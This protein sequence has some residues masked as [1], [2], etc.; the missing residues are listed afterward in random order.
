MGRYSKAFQKMVLER[1]KDCENIIAFSE[2]LGVHRP[3][4]YKWRDQSEH[5][6]SLNFNDESSHMFWRLYA[7]NL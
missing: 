6:V 5:S 2:K 7:T 3:L 1:L 4:P